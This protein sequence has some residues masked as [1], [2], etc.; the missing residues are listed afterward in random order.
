M[1]IRLIIRRERGRVELL[2]QTAG[3]ENIRAFT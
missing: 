1:L 3:I 2:E